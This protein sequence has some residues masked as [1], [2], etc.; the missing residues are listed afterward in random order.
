MQPHVSSPPAPPAEEVALGIFRISLPLPWR[1]RQI[2]CYVV[3]HGG[4]CTIVDTG[5]QSAECLDGLTR[6]LDYLGIGL[7]RI[8]QIVVTHSHVDH[9]GQAGRLQDLTGARLFLHRVEA[10]LLIERYVEPETTTRA[11]QGFMRGY[12]IPLEHLGAFVRPARTDAPSA[13]PARPDRLVADGEAIMV[14]ESSLRVIWTPGHS[15]GHCCYYDAERRVLFSG[16]HV[17]PHITPN[18]GRQPGENH[19]AY[20]LLDYERSIAKLL[21]LDLSVTLP[22]HGKLIH[23]FRAR[24]AQL[25]ASHQRRRE[26]CEAA[27]RAG[28]DTLAEITAAV[29]GPHKQGW[30]LRGA[31]IETL[32][33]LDALVLEGRLASTT[34]GGVVR[35]GLPGGLGL[36]RAGCAA[37]RLDQ[38]AEGPFDQEGADEDQREPRHREEAVELDGHE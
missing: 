33:H 15:P 3:R 22:G 8:E 37:G 30:A 31:L 32:S 27:V 36:G 25:L 28:Y 17:L 5:I 2:N 35:F 24:A 11:M 20:P 34:S 12:G 7:A 19:S 10:N 18:V 13:A 4:T 16:D 21:T 6:G 9:I 23:D 38:G 26:R 1:V 14:G 29:F